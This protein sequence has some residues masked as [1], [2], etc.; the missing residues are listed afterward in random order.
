[1]SDVYRVQHVPQVSPEQEA[2]SKA[3]AERGQGPNRN[4]GAGGINAFDMQ[5]KEFGVQQ[6]TP[7]PVSDLPFEARSIM[8]RP[9]TVGEIDGKSLIRYQGAE[10][11][12]KSAV[13]LGLI[14]MGPDGRYRLPLE[15]P[16]EEP[17]EEP[18]TGLPGVF[19]KELNEF[20]QQLDGVTGSVQATNTLAAKAIQG[21]ARGDVTTAAKDLTNFSGSKLDPT[22]A[23]DLIHTALERGSE[24]VAAY[25]GRN[26]KGV[27]GKAVVEFA[28]QLPASQR[29]NIAV[30]ILHG[31]KRVIPEL[32][33][34]FQRRQLIEGAKTK[35]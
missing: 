19:D 6:A 34:N 10:F 33:S 12:A 7:A 26:F 14:E 27:D 8:G 20:A 9:L 4:I 3:A 35:K 24:N 22:A 5:P 17:K 1:M 28:S 25:I 31:D 16:K 2:L 21:A 18:A 13:A 29:S 23:A 30:R 15:K 32:V 11:T